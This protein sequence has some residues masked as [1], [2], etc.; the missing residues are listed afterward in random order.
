MLAVL[1]TQILSIFHRR[2]EIGTLMALGVTRSSVITM[3]TFEGAMNA[4]L[5]ALAGALYGGPLLIV[6]MRAGIPMP[7]A[8]EQAGFPIGERL[9]PAYG[10]LLVGGT[11]ILVL[12][13]TTIV[14]Y[15]PTRRIAHLKPTEALRGKLA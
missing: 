5:A 4:V 12:V 10:A 11:T 14:S 7:A 6:A 13:V 3:F 15:L 8:I 2:K 9:Y 1:D